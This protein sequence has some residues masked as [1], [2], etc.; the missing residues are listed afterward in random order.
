MENLLPILNDE[1][2]KELRLLRSY[3]GMCESVTEFG[4][5]DCTSTWWLLAGRPA[6]L[7][8]Y[9]IGD[10]SHPYP[11]CPGAVESEVKRVAEAAQE[12]GIKYK[13]I[14][15]DT[16]QIEIAET[17]LLF[18]DSSHSYAH[19]KKELDRH[20]TKVRKFI[21]MHDTTVFADHDEGGNTPGL[22]L[23]ISEF[24]AEHSQWKHREE[25]T[26]YNGLTIL[27]KK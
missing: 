25:L 24:L 14:L 23:A 9:D 5:H 3:S 7:T 6:R 2:M 18:I 21:A 17:D 13:F 10:T 22:A 26:N 11:G 1:E 8:S 15:G 12:Y 4:V 20:H 16:T 19:V 27:E